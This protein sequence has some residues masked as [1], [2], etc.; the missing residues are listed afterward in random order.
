MQRIVTDDATPSDGK[1]R[2]AAARSS[3]EAIWRPRAA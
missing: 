3:R 2:A 1:R